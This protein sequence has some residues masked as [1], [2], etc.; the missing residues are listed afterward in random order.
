M[1]LFVPIL[2]AVW[3]LVAVVALLLCMSARRTD[4]ELARSDL[5]PVVEISAA[6]LASRR[7]TAG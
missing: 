7:H 4:A 6:S 2:I 5:T 3:L 1:P